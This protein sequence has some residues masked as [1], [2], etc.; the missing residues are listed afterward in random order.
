M[1][2]EEAPK[3]TG[4]RLTDAEYD[5]AK[6]LYER[7]ETSLADIAVK[8]G[9]TRQAL[10]QR[11]SKD[12]IVRGSKSKVVEAE[13]AVENFVNNRSQWIEETRFQGYQALKQV[14]LVARKIAMDQL[15]KTP[16]APMSEADGDLRASGRLNKILVDN[17]GMS[18]NILQA[19]RHVEENNLPQLL[20]ED[21][22]DEDILNHHKSTG[23]LDPDATVE[24]ML[25]ETMGD[26]DEG[27]D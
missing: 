7:G 23:V 10:W 22:T 21:L 12:K 16:P 27:D 20:V 3:S 9:I 4:K 26:E 11:F 13:K 6:E 14:Q 25:R 15:K 17:I 18:L 5:A 2:E 19:D 24:D 8:F 1:S